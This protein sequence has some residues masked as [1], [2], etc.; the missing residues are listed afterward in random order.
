MLFKNIIY[1][2]CPVV[3]LASGGQSRKNP[4]VV[5]C[6]RL[7]TQIATDALKQQL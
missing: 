4:I 1:R 5:D 6:H 3:S 2:T 7:A